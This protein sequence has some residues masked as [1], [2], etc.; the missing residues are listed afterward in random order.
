M[1]LILSQV[2]LVIGVDLAGKFMTTSAVHDPLQLT[3]SY[4][5]N[6]ANAFAQALIEIVDGPDKAIEEV[7]VSSEN[8]WEQIRSWM[9]ETPKASRTYIPDAIIQHATRCPDASAVCSW[10]AEVSYE[11]LEDF[12][13]RLAHHLQTLGI[14]PESRVLTCFEKSAWPIITLLAILKAGG[15]FVPIDTR[16]PIARITEIAEQTQA[17]LI[18]ASS[19]FPQ[20]QSLPTKCL[21]INSTFLNSLPLQSTAPSRLVGPHN[22]AYILFTSGSTGQPKGVVIEHEALSTSIEA[23][24]KILGLTPES[25]ALQFTSYTFDPSITE[26]FATLL[27]GGCV[28]VP[29]Q[30]ARVTDLALCINELKVGQESGELN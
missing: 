18:L 25:R 23:H 3:H 20:L 14:G 13:N 22:M 2:A 16:Y 4:A 1:L 8:T 7:D 12:S 10:D 15:A 6:L 30:N 24:G 17:K 26:I 19:S 5:S 27:Y 11:A 21:I 29:E 9:P 28:C